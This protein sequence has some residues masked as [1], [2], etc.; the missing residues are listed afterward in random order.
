MT[1]SE[2]RIDRSTQGDAYTNAE[3]HA[4]ASRVVAA[5]PALVTIAVG[6]MLLF[7]VGFL[8]V[9]AVHNGAHDTRHANGFA[10]H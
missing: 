8:Q 7:C 4:R 9:S 3:A 1:T 2:M 5:A 10:C 6:L